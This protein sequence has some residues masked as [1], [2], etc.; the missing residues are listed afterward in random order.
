[1]SVGCF[2]NSPEDRWKAG[3]HEYIEAQPTCIICND[4]EQLRECSY[5]HELVCEDCYSILDNRVYC[6]KCVESE[7]ATCSSCNKLFL[8]DNL[9]CECGGEE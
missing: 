2:D 4:T 9:V 3:N 8:R 1:M 7:W 6:P 5:C